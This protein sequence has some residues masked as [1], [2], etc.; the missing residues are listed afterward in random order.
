MTLDRKHIVYSFCL[1]LSITCLVVSNVTASK[2]YDVSLLGFDIIVPVGTTLFCMTF[3]ATDVIS[4]IWGRSHAL[5]VVF[6]GLFARLVTAGFFMLAVLIDGAE[7]WNNQEAYQSILGASSRILIGGVVGYTV[8]SVV[9]A[10]VFHYFREKHKGK[11][12]L[13]IRNN[14]S[15]FTA[16]LIGATLFV[17]IAFYGVVPNEKLIQIVA[18]NMII[19]WLMAFIDTPLVYIIRNYALNRKLLDFRG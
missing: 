9:D 11:N 2:V 15:T 6:L 16:H 19:K 7:S 18:G 5:F 13:F 8:A 1:M 12:L 17:T 10:Y 4:E 3:L 14:V